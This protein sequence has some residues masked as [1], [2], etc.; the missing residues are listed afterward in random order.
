[1]NLKIVL[2][3]LSTMFVISMLVL[4]WFLVPIG[5][6][7]EFLSKPGNS[8]F[9]ISSY[10]KDMQFY[11]NLR[12]PDSKISYRIESCSL[13]R[14]D[15]VEKAFSDISGVSVLEFYPVSLNEEIHVTC[16]EKAQQPEDGYF[17]A[18]EG[19]PVTIIA[20]DKFNV[21]FEGKVL[22]FRDSQ[23]EI[24]NVATHEILHALGFQ[25][26]VNK[27]NIMF[28]TTNCKQTFG[29]DIPKFINELYSYP[30]IPDLNLKEATAITHGR[31]LDANIT[32]RNSGLKDSEDFTL[33]IYADGSLAKE[34]K[35][36]AIK[37]GEGK[38]I[39]LDNIPV[40]RTGVSEL[41][42]LIETNSEELEKENNEKILNVKN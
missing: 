39:I 33:K 27:G 42:F 29:D 11:P 17:V 4:Y 24:P 32:V 31:Y 38:I 35:S 40:S 9:S 18:G 28:N 19:G 2:V 37:I 21:I 26:S 16:D 22:L 23:C 3:I 1:M 20:G 15:E 34:L 30:S 5:N 36:E 6:P 41:K 25:H 7:V 13:Q 14:G 8:N 10:T 12:Y